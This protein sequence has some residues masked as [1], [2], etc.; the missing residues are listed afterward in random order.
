[1]HRHARLLTLALALLPLTAGCWHHARR[2]CDGPYGG[3]GPCGGCG[4]SGD[5]G[6][7]ESCCGAEPY[8]PAEC[9]S[10]GGC[11]P[12]GGGGGPFQHTLL[13]ALWLGKD[14]YPCDG[15]GECYLGDWLSYPP[16]C[17]PC[18]DCGNF[19]GRPGYVYAHPHGL[20][21]DDP[22]L[23]EDAS[24]RL[25]NAGPVVVQESARPVHVHAP[26]QGRQHVHAARQQPDRRQAAQPRSRMRRVV[27][28]APVRR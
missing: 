27:H 2:Y 13:G 8:G 6:P 19:T 15:C 16:T 14:S 21:H 22:V 7:V 17:E 26:P 12:C 3:C 18:D 20:T 25:P 11:G 28:E 4:S 1:M 10:G 24:H 5:C 9:D 23:Y